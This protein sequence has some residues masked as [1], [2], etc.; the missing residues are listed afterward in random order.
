MLPIPRYF[1]RIKIYRHIFKL[2]AF[3]FDLKKVL[4]AFIA[5]L[6]RILTGL[7]IHF[8]YIAKGLAFDKLII[9]PCYLA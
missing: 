2:V 6:K 4:G 3:S 7:E 1:Y 5:R 9:T 8:K